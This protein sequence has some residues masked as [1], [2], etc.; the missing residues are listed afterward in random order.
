MITA[1]AAGAI[2]TMIADTMIPEAFE[3]THAM[4]GL[5]VSVGFLVAFAISRLG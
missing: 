2:R 5:V 1:V 3:N 4:T